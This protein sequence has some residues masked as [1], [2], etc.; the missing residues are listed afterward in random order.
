MKNLFALFSAKRVKVSLNDF[1]KE[2]I[3]PNVLQKIRGGGEPANREEIN[4]LIRD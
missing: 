4:I 1:E 3:G 2:A